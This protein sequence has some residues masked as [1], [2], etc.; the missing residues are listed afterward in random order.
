MGL[1]SAQ[2]CP[3]M[4]ALE[5]SGT[6]ELGKEDLRGTLRLLLVSVK[7]TQEPP[8]LWGSWGRSGFPGAPPT[9]TL[10]SLLRPS[11]A[12]EH[13]NI[14]VTSPRKHWSPPKGRAGGPRF[15]SISPHP[16]MAKSPKARPG[17][18][19]I[20]LLPPNLQISRLLLLERKLGSCETPV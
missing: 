15:H 7:I 6:L 13:R 14:P 20:P 19:D 4:S 17:S 1:A 10:S 9:P 16:G 2:K 3:E 12:L 18:Q 8:L 5:R 11:K